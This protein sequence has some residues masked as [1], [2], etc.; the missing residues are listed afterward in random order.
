[1]SEIEEHDIESDEEGKKFR[2]VVSSAE[3]A[4]NIIRDKLGNK[5][6]VLSVRQIEGKGLRSI[7]SSPKLEV[8]ITIPTEKQPST[9]P[10]PTSDQTPPLNPLEQSLQS[11]IK[12][13]DTP[14]DIPPGFEAISDEQAKEITETVA[15][16]P[17]IPEIKNPKKISSIPT[18]LK[19]I[20]FDKDM[21][22]SLEAIPEWQNIRKM[23]VAHALS[24]ISNYL[25]IEFNNI[26]KTPIDQ[27]IA[28]IGTPSVGKTT[29][30]CKLLANQ[31]FFQQ[32]KVHVVK[33]DSDTPNP[34][35]ALRVF[36]DI[37]GVTMHRHVEDISNIPSDEKIYFDIPGFSLTSDKE[38]DKLKL[39]LDENNIKTRI[40]ILNAAY[41]CDILKKS[42][43]LG[44][45]VD[46][47][48]L[49]FT[50]LDELVNS[51]K[52]WPFI[53]GSGL[54]TMYLCHGQNITSDFTEDILNYL[55]AN[56]FPRQVLTH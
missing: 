11:P 13:G 33:L 51:T 19:K 35:D 27:R 55:L 42:L 41:E 18:I 16:P 20:G 10:A 3:E 2:L 14:A 40:L 37:L 38:W 9:T 50:H 48:H 12:E 44:K 6:R 17:T 53:F 32:Q 5:A 36:C 43:L 34:D 29:T 7:L 56:T 39:S 54:N 30:L 25:K 24:E 23:P 22:T 26:E 28:L 4:V 45:R 46:C 21:I 8:I 49:I 31:V 15:A 47:S 52:I 1:M